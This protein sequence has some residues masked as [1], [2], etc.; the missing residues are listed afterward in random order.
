MKRAVLMDLVVVLVAL[1]LIYFVAQS[2]V[3]A[4]A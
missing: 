2:S 4:H 1:A 3:V